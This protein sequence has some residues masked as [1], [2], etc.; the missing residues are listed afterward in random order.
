MLRKNINKWA[1]TTAI[2]ALLCGNITPALAADNG[3]NSGDDLD[4]LLDMPIK[5]LTNM[6]VTSVSKRAEKASEA[7]AAIY[8]ITQED[9]R[10]SGFNSLPE[11]LRMVPGVQV[12]RIN[13]GWWAIT[14]RGN[15]Q[16]FGNKLLVLIDGRS[17]YNPLFSGVL[18]EEQSTPLEDIERIEVIRGPGSTLYGANAVNGVINIITKNSKDTQGNL[19]SVGG[20]NYD[21]FSGLY[22]YGGRIS[23]TDTYRTYINN[24]EQGDS[25][26]ES[27]HSTFDAYDMT[28]GGFRY[29]GGDKMGNANYTVSSDVYKGDRELPFTML[30]ATNAQG[31]IDGTQVHD[32]FGGNVIGKYDKKLD[33]G[34]D[35][36][37]QAYYDFTG[38]DAN[39]FGYKISTVDLDAQHNINLSENHQ[40]MWGLG[41]RGVLA[42]L[43][44]AVDA[45]YDRDNMQ[46]NLFS[47]FAQ[48]KIQ[49]VPDEL[50]LTLGS[51]I[52]HNSFS[53]VE[54]EPNARVTWLP[55]QTQTV[56]GAVTRAVR[57]PSIAERTITQAIVGSAFGVASYQG[58]DD[59]TSEKLIAYELGYRNQLTKTFSV[60]VTT[61][62]NDYD[63]LRTFA[64]TS[65]PFILDIQNN[66]QGITR[67]FEVS[68]N[69]QVFRDWS[70][71]GSYSY[72]DPHLKNDEPATNSLDA[73][74]DTSP[75]NM[76]NIRSHYDISSEW[77][78]NN[79]VYYMSKIASA[80]ITD[81][82]GVDGYASL[83]ANVIY[84]PAKGIELMLSGENLLHDMHQ[85]FGSAP[86]SIPAE[87][88]RSVFGKVT[89]RF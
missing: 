5:D 69:W 10:R 25:K 60:D 74:K 33:N 82:H 84:K 64:A 45:S 38:R 3:S 15:A 29:D 77:E 59:V 86:Y 4:K 19:A 6:E 48:D 76:F 43:D 35:V 71:T 36:Q 2:V 65:N 58:N 14:A 23:D 12:S 57:T 27:S 31:S 89:F 67:G 72:L 81:T 46:T 37:L 55:T 42:S 80:A 66:A 18:W 30:P 39:T 73:D 32:M 62:I 49:I 21:K 70:L 88:P 41:Y 34:S 24:Y 79:S 78:F 51:K 9:I 61:F 26:T 40:F 68:S 13:S 22:R 52:E 11:V 28:R 75:H 44:S 50:Y 54:F 1:L 20:G 17:I 56:W 53:G 7:A 16:P 87:I 47:G 8:V 85:E 63:S 83:D